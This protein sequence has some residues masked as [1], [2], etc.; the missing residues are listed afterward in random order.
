MVKVKEYQT[1]GQE[2]TLTL[3]ILRDLS[4]RNEGA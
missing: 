3:D 1:F 2:V 4:L